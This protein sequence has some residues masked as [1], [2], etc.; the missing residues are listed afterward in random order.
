[1]IEVVDITPHSSFIKKERKFD[2]EEFTPMHSATD[3]ILTDETLIY[4]YK[5]SPIYIDFL[6]TNQHTNV[7]KAAAQYFEKIKNDLTLR[8]W[9]S[10]REKEKIYYLYNK[11]H[12]YNNLVDVMEISKN[13]FESLIEKKNKEIKNLQE[14]IYAKESSHEING[15]SDIDISSKIFKYITHIRTFN[16]F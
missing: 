7:G 1:L 4:Y 3:N 10:M 9:S 11:T 6:N 16:F 12:Y 14:M 8:K 13:K 5:G 2:E 15:Y